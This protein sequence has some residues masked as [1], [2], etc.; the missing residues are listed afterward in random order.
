MLF[1][2]IE[3]GSY[4]PDFTL[5]QMEEKE[6]LLNEGKYHQGIGKVIRFVGIKI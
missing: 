3:I 1:S 5:I 4:F 2:T 6:V